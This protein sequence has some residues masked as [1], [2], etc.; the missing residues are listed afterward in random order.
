M[1]KYSEL[2]Y[3]LCRLNDNIGEWK[4]D[5]THKGTQE[6]PIHIPFPIYSETVLEF[7][8]AV[9]DYNR[10][11]PECEM[12]KYPEILDEREIKNIF[13]ADID[14]LDEK[15]AL[16]LLMCIVDKER[17]CDGLVYNN[18]KEGRIQALLE[19]LKELDN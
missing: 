15:G 13:A 2:T 19:R 5:N 9:Y 8:H 6:D 18:L 12:K 1:S 11:H 14:S 17:F 16:A 4:F 10:N 7:V 3:F